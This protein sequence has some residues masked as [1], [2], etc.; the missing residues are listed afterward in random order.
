[1]DIDTST[2]TFGY[3]MYGIPAVVTYSIYGYLRR[4]REDDNCT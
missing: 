4:R 1:M 2:R 3:L